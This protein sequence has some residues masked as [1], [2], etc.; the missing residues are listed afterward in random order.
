MAHELATLEKG[1]QMADQISDLKPV[2]SIASQLATSTKTGTTIDRFGYNA[3]SV[4]FVFGAWTDGTYTP[5]LTESDDDS[6]YS[7]VAAGDLIASPITA[8]A[9]A[10]VSS[11]GG[12]NKVQSV[13]YKGTKRYIRPVVTVTGSPSTGAQIGAYGLLGHPVNKPAA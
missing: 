12:Q 9:I 11:S 10:A 13:G 4:L 8:Q 2:H 1:I 3:L 5:K 6:S 7:D